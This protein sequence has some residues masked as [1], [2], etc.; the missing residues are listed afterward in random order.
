LLLFPKEM[1][2]TIRAMQVR[3]A[4]DFLVRQAAQQAA[5]EGVSLSDLEK[6]MMYFTESP[7]A[8]ED[9][10]KL[11][12][13]FEAQYDSEEY[14]SKISKLLH[15]AHE[16]VKKESED[17]RARWDGAIKCLRRGDHYLLVM[18][19]LAPSD[20][21]PRGDSL[22]LLAAGLVVA[23][24]VF[25]AGFFADKLEPQWRWLQKKIPYPNSH[26]MFGIFVTIVLAIFF[27][28]RRAGNVVEWLLDQTLFRFLGPK[29]D[30]KDLE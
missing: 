1:K 15:H 21:R 28:P 11:H 30:G 18:W 17:A 26:V 23:A 2:P 4:K 7:D 24:L 6:R 19:D 9:P 20:E 14:E 8:V 5:L 13:E 3:E 25:V 10:V 16:R 29:K 12:E 27:F 22:K